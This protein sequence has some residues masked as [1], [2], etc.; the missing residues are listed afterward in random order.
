MICNFCGVKGHIKK[1]CFKLKNMHRDTVNLV[2]AYKSG[3]SAERHISEMLERMQ[4]RESDDEESETD[5]Y[6]KRQR[7]GASNTNQDL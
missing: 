3:P 6:W 7:H 1:K 4:T 5:T 2:E